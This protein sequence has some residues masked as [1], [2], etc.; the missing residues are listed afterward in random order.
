[1][2]QFPLQIT[3][4]TEKEEFSCHWKGYNYYIRI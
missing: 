1:M 3:S 2:L 4:I